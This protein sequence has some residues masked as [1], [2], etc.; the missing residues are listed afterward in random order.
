[1]GLTR[2]AVT[3][4]ADRLIT[5]GFVARQASPDDSRAQ[6]LELTAIGAGL[7]P[8]L[9]GLAD[10]NDAECFAH[11]SGDDH[12]TFERILKALVTRLGI[13]APPIE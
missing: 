1:M 7:V 5:K 11:L 3:K 8:D 12:Q 6:T 10:Q 9:A 4:L 13:T 2:G